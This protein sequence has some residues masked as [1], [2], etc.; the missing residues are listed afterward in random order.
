[1]DKHELAASMMML[2]VGEFDV[3]CSINWVLN[4]PVTLNH[5]VKQVSF[6]PL[7]HGKLCITINVSVIMEERINLLGC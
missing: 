4:W 2:D 3:I 7:S 5:F 6:R 1:M